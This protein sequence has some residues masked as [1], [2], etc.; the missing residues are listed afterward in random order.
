MNKKILLI[1]GI[2]IA[3]LI[4]GLALLVVISSQPGKLDTFTQCLQE[5]K[6][7]FY[8]AFWC[9]HCQNQKALFGTS[10]KYLPYKECST[11]DGKKQIQACIDKKIATYPTWEFADGTRLSGEISLEELAKKTSCALP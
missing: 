6:A 11:S 7:V 10:E 9:S 2:G 3:L 4:I 5:K 8:G 1:T